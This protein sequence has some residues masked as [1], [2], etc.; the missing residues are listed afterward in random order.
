MTLIVPALPP[1]P[2]HLVAEHREAHER[3][4]AELRSSD[5]HVARLFVML[6]QRLVVESLAYV[7]PVY[8]RSDDQLMVPPPRTFLTRLQE[9]RMQGA[10]ASFRHIDSRVAMQRA[11]EIRTVLSTATP[12]VLHALLEGLSPTG[13][14]TNPGML[15]A[16]PTSWKPEA[17]G[18]MHPPASMCDELVA[19]ALAIAA[20][21]PAPG[22][23]R[24]GWL[25][26]AM[27]SIHPFVDGNGRTS[28]ALYMA[29]AAD[30]LPLGID[31]GILEQWSVARFAYV[32]ALQAGQRVERYD[33]EAM[34]ALPFMTFSVNA[35]I[36][37]AEVCGRRLVH[38]AERCAAERRSLADSTAHATVVV[39]VEMLGIATFAELGRCGLEPPELAAAIDELVQAQVLTWVPRPP[40]RRTRDDR[41]AQGLMVSS[42][43]FRQ[44]R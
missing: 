38:I 6:Q 44:L 42:L 30:E 37:G 16:T 17:S 27:L 22:C 25:T 21:A 15:R 12:L 18:F 28:R 13:R 1:L 24:S 31:W 19:A 14:E 23:A 2:D 43:W 39:A 5:A 32:Q 9:L 10:W 26:Y 36:A 41:E 29:V 33:A 11:G 8:A 20:D 34:D 40:S 35:S 3:L 7:Q 4:A